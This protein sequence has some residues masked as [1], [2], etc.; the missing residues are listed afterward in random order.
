MLA[1]LNFS[2]AEALGNRSASPGAILPATSSRKLVLLGHTVAGSPT[3]DGPPRASACAFVPG[4]LCSRLEGGL[5]LAKV[6]VS[7]LSH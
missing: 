7:S 1:F 2:E 5:C 4:T 6:P 3:T